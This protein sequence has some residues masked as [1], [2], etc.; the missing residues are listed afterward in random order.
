V[1]TV[2]QSISPWLIG[3][4]QRPNLSRRSAGKPLFLRTG[5]SSHH[6]IGLVIPMSGGT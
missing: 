3:L 2:Q 1:Q 6:H 5:S 4:L